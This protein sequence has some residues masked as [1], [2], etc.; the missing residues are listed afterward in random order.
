MELSAPSGSLQV[1]LSGEISMLEGE[2]VVQRDLHRLAKWACVN[3][4]R[5]NKSK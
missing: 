5:L 1:T 3:Q 4:M 2:D